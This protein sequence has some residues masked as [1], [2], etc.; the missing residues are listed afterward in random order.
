MYHIRYLIPQTE[1][2]IDKELDKFDDS[3]LFLSY[4][5]IIYDLIVNSFF[6]TDIYPWDS[7]TSKPR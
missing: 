1:D 3:F 4:N 6:I 7:P 5:D 2:E